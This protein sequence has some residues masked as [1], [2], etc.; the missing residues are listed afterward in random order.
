MRAWMETMAYFERSSAPWSKYALRYFPTACVPQVT[1]TLKKQGQIFCGKPSKMQV[2]LLCWWTRSP[3][4]CAMWPTHT[5]VW[6]NFWYKSFTKSLDTCLNCGA[7]KRSQSALVSTFAH[8]DKKLWP[9]G[10]TH[11]TDK[12]TAATSGCCVGI[13][14]HGRPTS[15][16]SF[17]SASRW[18]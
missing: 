13:Y 12:P 11:K 3:P 5:T 9:P 14:R 1:S 18:P 10:G 17:V 7:N 8:I 6:H 16:T 4:K 2:K 15:Q